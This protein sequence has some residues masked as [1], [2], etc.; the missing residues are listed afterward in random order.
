MVEKKTQEKAVVQW[1]GEPITIT[2]TDVK[3]LICPLATDQETVVFLKTCQSL[4][5]NP[6]AGECYLI[7]YSEKDKAAIVIAIDSYLKAAETNDNYNGHEAGTIL[8][9]TA[10][11][12]EFREGSF[13]LEEEFDKLV[14]GWAK[15]YRKDRE[16]PFY[17][18]V[19][20]AECVRYAR[21]GHLTQ[22]WTENKQPMMLRKVALKRALVEA[23]PQLFVGAYSTAEFE[24]IPE[25]E[26]PPAYEKAGEANWKKW[27]V[28]QKEKGLTPNDVHTILGVTSLKEDW[29]EKGRT[30]EEAEDIIN[31]ALENQNKVKAAPQ[32]EE[33]T[34]DLFPPD[35]VTDIAPEPA[36]PKREPETIKTINDLYRACNEDF[37]VIDDDGK[38]SKMQPKEVLKELGYS[39]KEDIADTP[40]NCYR[41]IS[42]VRT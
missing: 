22:F 32:T 10:G 26:L 15:V 11:K 29:L 7:K 28:R 17:M 6:F 33:P 40:A 16:K 37:T 13:L 18:A 25:G 21:D 42:A 39:S 27:W 38:P 30:L 31:K 3:T 5:L 4:S 24:E 20:K 1:R 9:D 34:E 2:F 35:E 41:Q 12:L 36:K 19:N 23:F 14:G 8:R